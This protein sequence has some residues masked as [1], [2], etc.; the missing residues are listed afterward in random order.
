M[1]YFREK[2]TIVFL[3]QVPLG[4]VFKNDGRQIA[5]LEEEGS[6]FVAARGGAGGKGNSF[7]TTDV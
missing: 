7:F 6:L 4:T 5:S 1:H 3:L 2:T